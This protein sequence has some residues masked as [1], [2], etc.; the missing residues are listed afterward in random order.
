MSQGA[1]LHCA[2][3][4]MIPPIEPGALR[5]LI[6]KVVITPTGRRGEVDVRLFGDLGRCCSGRRIKEAGRPSPFGGF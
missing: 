1:A 3:S 5:A 2:K 6:D 4:G